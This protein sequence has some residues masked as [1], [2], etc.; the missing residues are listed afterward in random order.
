MVVRRNTVW[1][2]AILPVVLAAAAVA[3]TYDEPRPLRPGEILSPALLQSVHHVVQ[4][5]DTDGRFFRFVID[6]EFGTFTAAS[7]AML[8]IR[9]GEIE[10]LSQAVNTLGADDQDLQEELH[11]QLSVRADSALDILARPVSTATSLAGQVADN[12]NETFSG[13]PPEPGSRSLPAG[14]YRTDPNLAIHR[15]NAAA[16]WGF[17]P[18]SSN[19][20]V[21]DFLDLVARTRAGGRIGAGTPAIVTTS[22]ER[23]SIE[24]PEIDALVASR[25]KALEPR[26]LAR[27]NADL[28]AAMQVRSDVAEAFLTH[29]AY[30]PRHQTR[31]TRYLEALD[32]VVNRNAFVEA[33]LQAP[34]EQLVL[35]FEQAAMMLLHYHRNVAHIGKLHAGEDLLQAITADNRVV[36]LAPVDQVMWTPLSERLFDGLAGRGKEAGFRAWELV[37]AGD[38]SPLATEELEK[39]GYT[40]RAWYVR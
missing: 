31:I 28:L 22:Q 37:V 23:L 8:R 39:R 7:L 12:L 1:P 36:H 4:E 3:G 24:D 14:G 18:Y 19:Q 9:V 33:A 2:A 40:V 11:G 26:E 32:G 5:A 6:S 15:R 10:R 20:R 30:S 21:Q 17:D 27:E 38:V 16:Q 29:A 13:P 34:G 25:L 35:A